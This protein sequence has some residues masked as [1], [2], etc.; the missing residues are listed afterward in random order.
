METKTIK[1]VPIIFRPHLVRAIR[2][3]KKTQTRRLKN[4]KQ[5]N[6]HPDKYV[7]IHTKKMEFD[8]YNG[9]YADFKEKDNYHRFLIKSPYQIGQTLWIKETCWLNECKHGEKIFY[10]EKPV[11]KEK[12]L[13][14]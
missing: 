9:T 1:E 13:L 14:K 8:C 12:R 4:I 5:L 6:D 11:P 3:G 10:D 2:F 7:C